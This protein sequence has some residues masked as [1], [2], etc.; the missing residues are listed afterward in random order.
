[1]VSAPDGDATLTDGERILVL[2][3]IGNPS[4]APTAKKKGTVSRPVPHQ[5]LFLDRQDAPTIDE[6]TE[7]YAT[8]T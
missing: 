2:A 4:D 6:Q 5:F 8:R 3:N 1:M 7:A